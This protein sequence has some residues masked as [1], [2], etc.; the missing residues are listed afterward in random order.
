MNAVK[1]ILNDFEKN[2]QLKEGKKSCKPENS[3]LIKLD[4]NLT[5]YQNKLGNI[6]K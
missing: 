1:Q 3:M 6:M 5:S 4:N 2:L